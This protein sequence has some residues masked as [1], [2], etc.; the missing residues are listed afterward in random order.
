MEESIGT[1]RL[2]WSLNVSR[3]SVLF[4]LIESLLSSLMLFLRVN[5]SVLWRCDSSQGQEKD[6]K[7]RCRSSVWYYA[8][9]QR[10][11]RIHH[12]KC[13]NTSSRWSPETQISSIQIHLIISRTDEDY[14]ADQIRT[15]WHSSVIND[16][17][18]NFLLILESKIS[19]MIVN[20][21]SSLTGENNVNIYF[22]QYL[23]IF[24]RYQQ[25][26]HFIP[27]ISCFHFIF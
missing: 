10:C 20:Y 11:Q 13:E 5:Q 3:S 23:F 7:N 1:L 12:V 8:H 19:L 17:Q 15:D 21:C 26:K 14:R 6:R 9:D 4:T 24:C 18:W 2:D 22:N 27:I 25:L 16:N